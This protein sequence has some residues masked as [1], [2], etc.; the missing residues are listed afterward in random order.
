M[1]SDDDD[2][3]QNRSYPAE[4]NLKKHVTRLKKENEKEFASRLTEE[5]WDPFESDGVIA[6]KEEIEKTEKASWEVNQTGG[7]GE[8]PTIMSRYID[9]F[10]RAPARSR[11]ERATEKDKIVPITMTSLAETSNH[12][13]FT[14]SSSL[15]SRQLSKTKD[16]SAQ[17]IP[18]AETQKDS[19]EN[20]EEL[21]RRIEQL[22]S[23]SQSLSVSVSSSVS[24]D[25]D[26]L[27]T[28]QRSHGG[29][30]TQKSKDAD[31]FGQLS[32]AKLNAKG[33]PIKK[34]DDILYKWR[35][36]RKIEGAKHPT[37]LATER[38]VFKQMQSENSNPPESKRWHGLTSAEKPFTEIDERQRTTI[39]SLSEL[40]AKLKSSEVASSERPGLTDGAKPHRGHILD[41]VVNTL[42]GGSSLSYTETNE[43]GERNRKIEARNEKKTIDT[44]DF[45]CQTEGN[46]GAVETD[47]QRIKR[48]LNEQ[49]FSI[50]ESA[51][52]SLAQS[53]DHQQLQYSAMPSWMSGPFGSQH[54]NYPMPSSSMNHSCG[55]THQNQYQMQPFFMA[56]SHPNSHMYPL[57]PTS[58]QSHHY[59]NPPVYNTPAVASMGDVGNSYN[60]SSNVAV[61]VPPVSPRSSQECKGFRGSR[62]RP[63]KSEG[64]A[65]HQQRS[66]LGQKLR[67]LDSTITH[68]SSLETS[69]NLEDTTLNASTISIV[70]TASGQQVPLQLPNSQDK[71]ENLIDDSV[72]EK[73]HFVPKK[74]SHQKTKLQKAPLAPAKS[75]FQVTEVK[76]QTRENDRIH[77]KIN[78][79]VSKLELDNVKSVSTQSKKVES[80]SKKDLPCLVSVIKSSADTLMWCKSDHVV[81]K[82]RLKHVDL[83]LHVAV[84]EQCVF[85][86]S[87]MFREVIAINSEELTPVVSKESNETIGSEAAQ[88]SQNIDETVE[89][90]SISRIG[91][92]G[93]ETKESGVHLTS[94]AETSS[95]AVQTEVENYYRHSANYNYSEDFEA[96]TE[97]VCESLSTADQVSTLSQELANPKGSH[98]YLKENQRRNIREIGTQV[99]VEVLFQGN[100]QNDDTIVNTSAVSEPNRTF[101][102]AFVQ[103]EG[104]EQ[105]S[106]PARKEKSSGVETVK[107]RD[108]TTEEAIDDVE[109]TSI[110]GSI[111]ASGEGS[112]DAEEISDSEVERVLMESDHENTSQ[113]DNVLDSPTNAVD[114]ELLSAYE[115]ACA[116][117][118]RLET[119]VKILKPK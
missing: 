90:G 93:S 54:V 15:L 83:K 7:S 116:E 72:A 56:P 84:P 39:V 117:K 55:F 22:L 38:R 81:T 10:R 21:N 33:G 68:V 101:S 118:E 3:V 1:D 70:S 107:Q 6:I 47:I 41:A 24:H 87:S 115:K 64:G 88:E 45:A 9:N 27:L 37:R 62:E 59:I 92:Y 40:R 96:E 8:K 20:L 80:V 69:T 11:Q 19:G 99:S 65:N 29:N 35:L 113:E 60:D 100:Q 23:T 105:Q 86:E 114:R 110:N 31:V 75:S 42:E 79:P 49:G 58:R 13:G 102:D 85:R 51:S 95:S 104:E 17:N 14:E 108:G 12:P 97:S 57:P 61:H 18:V 103:T 43:I 94:K 119:L 32:V 63:N 46:V 77:E 66:H 78:I 36:R 71:R 109:G 67:S 48:T 91:P 82:P 89:N 74:R 52:S 111:C 34:E 4:F 106:I 30:Q 44:L 2:Y 50:N 26:S 73:I 76:H 112:S 25:R 5:I 28:E 98:D 16:S 53:R